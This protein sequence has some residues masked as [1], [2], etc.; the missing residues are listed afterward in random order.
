[1]EVGTTTF[2]GKR[3]NGRS[4]PGPE[5]VYSVLKHPLEIRTPNGNLDGKEAGISC[6]WWQQ[7]N[8]NPA[9][10]S[11]I[12]GFESFSRLL[13]LT[14]SQPTKL[15]RNMYFLFP[16]FWEVS[17][18]LFQ[19]FISLHFY[20]YIQCI[21]IISNPNHASHFPRPSHNTSPFQFQVIVVFV[22]LSSSFSSLL[23]PPP[24][25]SSSC[26]SILLLPLLLLLL[27]LFTTCLVQLQRPACKGARTNY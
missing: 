15:L 2:S 18:F 1:M 10:A 17:V 9:K 20:T 7:E 8:D 14:L 21:L 5:R 27:I 6:S 24:P 26:P 16:L 23:P 13:A 3:P 4:P 22:V 25:S 12:L 11:A 19:N